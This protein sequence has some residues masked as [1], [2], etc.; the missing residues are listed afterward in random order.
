MQVEFG[1]DPH[2]REIS[3]QGVAPD[4]QAAARVGQFKC[5]DACVVMVSEGE[6]GTQGPTLP[7][8]TGGLGQQAAVGLEQKPA[9][10]LESAVEI[11]FEPCLN[12]LSGLQAGLNPFGP[13][14]REG[15]FGTGKT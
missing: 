12:L 13:V 2:G 14:R 10:K 7:V 4:R 11:D 1:N 8:L 9:G 15:R 3:A 6:S 5:A